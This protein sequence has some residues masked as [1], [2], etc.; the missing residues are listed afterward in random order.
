MDPA[1]RELLRLTMVPDL[2][3]K[4]I[5]ALLNTFG[6]TDAIARASAADLE[7]VRGIGPVI[8]RN[9]AQFFAQG[10]K[11]LDDEITLATHLGV[12]IV[13]RANPAYPSLLTELPDAPPLLFVRGDLVPERDRFAVAI[14]G[15]RDCTAYGLEQAERFAAVLASAGITII[16]GGAR[17]IDTAAHRGAMRAQGRTIAVLGCG[18]ARCYPP[19][20]AQLFEQISSR[21]AVV[22]ELPL[23]TSPES[24]NFPARNRIIS[25]MSIGVLV[26]EAGQKSGA[27]IT[28]R[29]AVE[30]HGRE[31]MAVP[32]RVDSAA[33]KGTNDLLKSGGAHLVT[34]P[35]DAIAILESQARHVFQGTHADRYSLFSESTSS[36][37]QVT[38]P[39]DNAA[40]ES[41]STGPKEGSIEAR[42]L[43]V[44]DEPR[45]LDELALRLSTEPSGL[46]SGLTILEIQGRVRRSGPRFERSRP[47][48]NALQRP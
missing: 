26:I 6:S 36:A 35:G 37:S 12:S 46:R 1:D 13:T 47:T 10:D 15:S 21:G 39:G 7:R 14:V 5:S 20:N 43:D 42:I 23:N 45:T 28:A 38:N 34:E 40:L 31:V 44:L 29:Q 24:S 2:G 22:S 9:A 33:S 8:A 17:G 18:L 27:L 25:G 3:P 30:E 16:S 11:P 48:A 32:G 4:R 41:I 19:E